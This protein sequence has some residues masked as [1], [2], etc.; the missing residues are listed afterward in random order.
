M[1]AFLILAACLLAAGFGV[2]LASLAPAAFGFGL[3][4][5]VGVF[6]VGVLIDAIRRHGFREAMEM[7]A[8]LVVGAVVLIGLTAR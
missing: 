1:T 7:A 6:I 3:F 4:L 5:V 2:L 8:F